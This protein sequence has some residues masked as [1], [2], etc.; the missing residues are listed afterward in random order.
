M[1]AVLLC[2]E[3]YFAK[4]LT[5][6]T[7]AKDAQK[8]FANEEWTTMHG[9]FA[10]MRGF[11]LRFQTTAVETSL[12]P[13][14]PSEP[15]RALA[16]PRPGGQP[17]A[18]YEQS[19]EDAVKHELRD[20]ERLCGEWC[21]FRQ[22]R[23]PSGNWPYLS[24]LK[25]SRME[26]IE[27]CWTDGSLQ[28]F[29]PTE[30]KALLTS[31]Q[32]AFLPSGTEV[33]ASPV[34]ETATT[35]V[36]S[37]L[38]GSLRHSNTLQSQTI[39]GEGD[40]RTPI[41]SARAFAPTS[42]SPVHDEE[43]SSIELPSPQAALLPHQS[44]E[45]KWPLNA[46]QLY[47]ANK[48]GLIG[49]PPY[50]SC[51]HLRNQSKADFMVKALTVWQILWLT[52][53]ILAR[54]AQSP[55]ISITLLEVTVLAFAATAIATYILLWQK[56]QDVKV[57]QYI[58]ALRPIT[59]EDVIQLAARAPTSTMKVYEFWLHGVAVRAMGDGIFPNTK[60]IRISSLPFLHPKR[61]FRRRKPSSFG[62]PTHQSNN[63][64]NNPQNGSSEKQPGREDVGEEEIFISP[65]PFGIGV[66][67]AIFGAVHL[68]ALNFY[69]PTRLEQLLW[70]I[71]CGILIGLP[72][73]EVGIYSGYMHWTKTRLD[74]RREDS[75]VN[76]VLGM[77]GKALIPVYL[78]ARLY[79][80]VET[81]RSLGYSKPDAFLEVQ[82]PSAVPHY[83]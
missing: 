39:N 32:T 55:P 62:Q 25:A 67:G 17:T 22:D 64:N 16:K 19:Y 51:E 72:A 42:E 63:D 20:C 82:W 5:E 23:K 10:N 3:F 50:I 75:K 73:V 83:M 65:I 28:A 46:Q 7:A 66:G 61:L 47:H 6:N 2:P 21:P 77:F 37:P 14:K 26:E 1:G 12:K 35:L 44:W 52:I 24:A 29:K 45:G 27:R 43:T 76:R 18:Y 34:P 80:M 48:I 40:H 33:Q 41:A 70:R 53:Q 30:H 11:V 57:P 8:E 13:G 15:G 68:A 56:P 36:N 9:F 79:L 59:R 78:V 4:A 81:F 60:G 69:F 71:S 58:D 38:E 74:K 54:S 49:D 31:L